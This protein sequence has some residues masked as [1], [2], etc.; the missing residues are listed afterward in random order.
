MLSGCASGGMLMPPYMCS[1]PRAG[2]IILCF[3]ELCFK[4][5]CFKEPV[6]ASHAHLA[7]EHVC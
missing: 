3:K 5:L 2:C 4:E 6:V 7:P 1:C